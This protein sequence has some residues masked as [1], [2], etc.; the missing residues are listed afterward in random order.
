MRALACVR[1][2][3]GELQPF[4]ACAVEL[5]LRMGAEVT[6]LSLCPPSAAEPLRALTRRG[7]SRVVLLSDPVYAGADTLVT[8]KILAAAAKKIGY[9]LIL[10]G[11]TTTEGETAQVGPML[12]T[13]LGLPLLP[14]VLAYE[15]GCL[16]LRDE[17]TPRALPAAALV[18]V[19]RSFPLRFP[20]LR[21]RPKEIET[22]SNAQIGLPPAA[23][24]LRGS[25]TRVL[26]A[27]EATIGVRACQHIDVCDIPALI[28][29]FRQQEKQAA[30]EF[31]P[32]EE[33]LP[34]VM[35]VGQ[36]AFS[37][38]RA[39]GARV[40]L[41]EEREPSVI[42]AAIRETD[43]DAVLFPATAE[44]RNLAPI[45]AAMLG[46]G[47]CA[48]CT[49]LSVKNG[50]L[51]LTRPARGGSVIADIVCTTRPAMATVRCEVRGA[52]I[53]LGLGKGTLG[54]RARFEALA[55]RLGASLAATRALVDAGG[56]PYREQIGLTGT[57]AACKIYLAVGLSGAVQHTC[58][59]DGA[60][61]VIAVN[62][63]RD[64]RIF[65]CANYGAQADAEALLSAFSL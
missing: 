65:S 64:A 62:P 42:V 59:L 55:Q 6:V 36:Q 34:L 43:P 16:T 14:S 52:E 27:R 19:E 24:G 57:K 47:L 37:A 48:D 11:R 40:S 8:A 26:S 9:D 44:G 13:L 18:T 21:S 1:V 50:E 39:V 41:L 38:A 12:A 5:A 10:C 7:G 63:D 15:N 49:G 46:A 17:E 35:A 28:D 29:R 25:P 30:G 4:D 31:L 51:I 60:D 45:V 23:C 53:L 54:M 58:A 3:G 32:S 33:K 2:A 22:W 56:A 20:G 61:V